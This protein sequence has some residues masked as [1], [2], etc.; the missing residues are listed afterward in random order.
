MTS[1][2]RAKTLQIS[3][4]NS[5]YSSYK[6]LH[7]ELLVTSGLI[8]PLTEYE[9]ATIFNQSCHFTAQQKRTVVPPPHPH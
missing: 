4:Y 7:L 2:R 3:I 5:N 8:I 9:S 1:G 6:S